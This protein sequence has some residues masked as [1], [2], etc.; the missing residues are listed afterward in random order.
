MQMCKTKTCSDRP[1]GE[2]LRPRCAHLTNAA[3]RVQDD[4]GVAPAEFHAGGVTAKLARLSPGSRQGATSAPEMQRHLVLVVE[5]LSLGMPLAHRQASGRIL[6]PTI[7]FDQAI[8]VDK[9][10]A[11]LNGIAVVKLR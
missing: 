1:V 6:R 4:D 2:F 7:E 10:L 9:A 11:N 3:A 5:F 8:K